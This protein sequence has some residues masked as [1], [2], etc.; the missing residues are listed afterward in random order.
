MRVYLK[1]YYGNMFMKNKVFEIDNGHNIFFRIKKS[2][3]EKG[4]EINT[5]DYSFGKN[6][7]ELYYYCDV[8]YPWEAVLWKDLLSHVDRNVLLNFESPL[9]NPFSQLGFVSRFFR[10]IYTWN[11]DLVDGK[12]YFKFL[13]P[14]VESKKIRPVVPFSKRKFAVIVISNRNSPFPFRILSRY[15][16]NGY[17]RRIELV[18]YFEKNKPDLM[19]FFGRGWKGVR[20]SG[21]KVYKGEIEGNNKLQYLSK[22]KFCFCFENTSAPGY[23]TEK[24]FDSFKAGCVPVYLGAPNVEEYISSECFIEYRDFAG[25]VDLVEYLESVS[26]DRYQKY[27]DRGEDFLSRSKKSG[28]WFI[29]GF[30]E[31][32]LKD[33]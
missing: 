31:V 5:I 19:D 29:E 17:K 13:V 1:P 23:V 11:D 6:D 10:K 27:L 16:D 4:V 22:Y 2:L 26:E 28:K 33:E 20:E 12:K 9:V 21:Y 24:I 18:R 25:N 15:K 3:F 7:G 8:P 30:E 32:F 14:Q